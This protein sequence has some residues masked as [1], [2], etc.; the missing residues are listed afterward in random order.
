MLTE[1]LETE[2][3]GFLSQYRDLRDK[4]GHK[5]ITRNGHLREREIQTGIGPVPVKLPRARDRQAEH[6]LGPISFKSSLIP[7][8]LR[9]TRSMEELIPWLFLKGISAG[10]FSEVLAA[11]DGIY[12]APCAW[13]KDNAF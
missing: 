4:Q 7:P 9:K 10:D 13:K 3:E 11:V 5:R 1:A 2:I 8:Y 6:E 12:N